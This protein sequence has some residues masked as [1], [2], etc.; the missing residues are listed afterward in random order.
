MKFGADLAGIALALT[1]AVFWGALPVALKQVVAVLDPTTIVW[2][3][4]FTAALWLWLCPPKA[5]QRP[6][7]LWSSRRGLVLVL[8]AAAGLGGNFV[9]FNASVMFLTAGG[10]Q[11][12]AQTGP[13]LLM[14]GSVLVLREPL[15]PVQCLGTAA[16]VLGLGL[17]FNERLA[18]LTVFRDGYGLG[19]LLGVGGAA[20]WA[21]YGLCQKVLLRETEPSRLMRAVY[22]CN[23]VMLFPFA[24][25]G[26]LLGLDPVQALCLAFCCVNTLV[27]YGAF[28]R[29]M[30]CCRT[31]K[32][33][34]LLT[35]TPLFTLGF[36]ELLH[37]LEPQW[38]PSDPLNLTGCIGA[39]IVVAGAALIAVGPLVHPDT[40]FGKTARASL[41]HAA[42]T[43]EAT[44]GGS[45]A[46]RWKNRV[47]FAEQSRR[48]D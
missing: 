34:A 15:H 8:A 39:V 4:F 35:T 31:A 42:A 14:L 7:T 28:S 16:L 11:I 2:I 23:A 44:A 24:A 5:L 12:I 48:H 18:A 17:F 33:G 20:V 3:R 13:M 19:L 36:A 46:D 32:V 47:F 38:F 45:T 27:A 21:V 30:T 37:I 40:L 6:G 26:D 22:T 9:L 41:I 1:T 25:P 29:A 43:Q 10:T